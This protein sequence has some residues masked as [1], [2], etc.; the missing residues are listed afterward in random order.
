MRYIHFVILCALALFIT[1]SRC[2][3]VMAPTGGEKDTIPPRPISFNPTLGQTNFKEKTILIEFSEYIAANGLTK[4]LLI[5]PRTENKFEFFIVKNRL[6]MVFEENFE[7]NTTYNFN[8]RE[9]IKDVTEGNKAKDLNIFFSTGAVLD[10]GMIVG[11]VKDILKDKPIKKSKVGLYL[12]ND[13]TD[14]FNKEPR[15]FASTSDETGEYILRNIK[16]GKYRIFA[17]QDENDNYKAEPTKEAYAFRNKIVDVTGGID[18]IDLHMIRVDIDSFKVDNGRINGTY[19]DIKSSKT[20]MDISVNQE[21][22]DI[23][24]NLQENDRLI[25]FYRT[26]RGI[27]STLVQFTLTDT[28]GQ[29][30]EKEIYLKFPPTRRKKESLEWSFKD[31]IYDPDIKMYTGEIKFSKPMMSINS[32]SIFIE[33]DSTSFIPLELEK[34]V[35]WNK[36]KDVLHYAIPFD[37]LIHPLKDYDTLLEK[38]EDLEKIIL[39]FQPLSFKSV[40]L[41]TTKK[42]T[43]EIR[44]GKPEVNE[45][46]LKGKIDIEEPYYIIELLDKEF[47]ILDTLR[48][49]K[50]YKFEGLKTQEYRLRVRVNSKNDGIWDYGNYRDRREPEQVYHY[51]E[52]IK[53]RTNWEIEGINIPFK[54]VD[55]D[56]DKSE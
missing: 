31:P 7:E 36:F 5:T 40:E 28:I 22:K 48:N 4:E 35:T 21:F 17:F 34:Y 55:E 29:K 26:K 15:Y 47:N 38:Y 54:P 27:D 44:F 30:V 10:T 19:Y 39:R 3:T 1:F 45:G 49:R 14:I 53:M 6:K 52:A 25:R 20:I 18:T 37:T 56:V 12:A 2:A 11:K 33:K 24:Y 42:Q 46:I 50:E 9:G 43:K 8:F 51:P 41:D 23:W 13:T 16:P 32:D